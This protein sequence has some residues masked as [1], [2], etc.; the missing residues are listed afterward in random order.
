[1]IRYSPTIPGY[2]PGLQQWTRINSYQSLHGVGR[3]SR[4]PLQVCNELKSGAA[5]VEHPEARQTAVGTSG[6]HLLAPIFDSAA[7]ADTSAKK[8]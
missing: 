7:H 8:D 2:R 6:Q 5:A 1:M 4:H 3:T